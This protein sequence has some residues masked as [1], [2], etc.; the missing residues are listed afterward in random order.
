MEYNL[1][2][3]FEAKLVAYFMPCMFNHCLIWLKHVIQRSEP[4]KSQLRLVTKSLSTCWGGSSRGRSPAWR[5]SARSSLLWVTDVSIYLIDIADDSKHMWASLNN[6]LESSEA[7]KNILPWLV[8]IEKSLAYFSF[9][10][11]GRDC[12]SHLL[13]VGWHRTGIFDVSEALV[14]FYFFYLAS[15]TK[16]SVHLNSP[17]GWPH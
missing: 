10:K 9:S 7:P 15:V 2:D 4:Q 5:K 6:F 17:S 12:P 3:G 8:N 11:T 16:T 13:S 1:R 14:S